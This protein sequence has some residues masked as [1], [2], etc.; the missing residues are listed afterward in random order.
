MYTLKNLES[1][2]M[3]VIYNIQNDQF[4]SIRFQYSDV[5]NNERMI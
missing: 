2:N 3:N 5:N 1:G 4:V